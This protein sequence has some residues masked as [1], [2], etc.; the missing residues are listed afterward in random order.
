MA[1][2]KKNNI[3]NGGVLA[4]LSLIFSLISLIEI[5]MVLIPSDT[6]IPFEIWEAFDFLLEILIMISPILSI[7]AILLGFVALIII[8]KS[9]IRR[10]W[11]ISVIGIIIGY[12]SLIT[13]DILFWRG[14]R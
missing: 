3:E 2:A 11:Y 9:R 5:I 14:D 10:Y 7:S 8:R 6:K 12:I 13:G 4:L 1:K